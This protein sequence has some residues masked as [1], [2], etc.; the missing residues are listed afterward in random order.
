MFFLPS[1]PGDVI[2]T[3]QEDSVS[4]LVRLQLPPTAE[5]EDIQVLMPIRG[6]ITRCSKIHAAITASIVSKNF[7]FS[8]DP[9][10][11]YSRSF[12]RIKPVNVLI[13]DIKTYATLS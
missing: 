5:L 10:P 2:S 12:L 4:V 1:K 8:I 3:P 7:N 13:E 6:R 9:I 11:L